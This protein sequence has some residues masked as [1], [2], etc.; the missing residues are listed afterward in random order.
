MLS[1]PMVWM[2]EQVS[3]SLPPSDSIISS[4]KWEYALLFG[5]DYRVEKEAAG[6]RAPGPPVVFIPSP[7]QVALG[8]PADS[9]TRL[10]RACGC[11]SAK[12]L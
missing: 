6:V 8:V 10:G 3:A 12:A 7:N 4:I 9:P 11:R 5:E 1:S 2:R